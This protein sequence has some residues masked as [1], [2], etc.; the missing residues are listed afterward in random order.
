MWISAKELFKGVLRHWIQ[1]LGGGAVT[2]STFIAQ[3]QGWDVPAWVFH[4]SALAFVGWAI[5]L[6]FHDLRLQ[7]DAAMDG[8]TSRRVAQRTADLLTERHAY[9]VHE[10]LHKAPRWPNAHNEAEA[11][12]EGSQ[13]WMAKVT[14]WNDEVKKL[15]LELDC[16]P[17]EVSQFWTISD[18]KP[19]MMIRGDNWEISV[20]LHDTRLDRLWEIITVY[21]QRA[22]AASSV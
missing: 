15:M 18:L 12:R 13:V 19:G 11:F 16:T 2:V 9:G 21:A 20:R 6:A 14:A 17:Q 3:G 8:L 5:L 7:C 10:L 1:L 4:W 22:R